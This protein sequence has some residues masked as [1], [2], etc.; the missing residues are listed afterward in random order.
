MFP[1]QPVARLSGAKMLACSDARAK[2]SPHA[3][4]GIV[5][6]L[7]SRNVA[8][9]CQDFE[10]VLYAQFAVHSF[11]DCLASHSA[12][13]RTCSPCRNPGVPGR[14]Q[15]QNCRVFLGHAMRPQKD[16]RG[17]SVLRKSPRRSV[18]GRLFVPD[19]PGRWHK[20]T[21]G[22]R[23]DGF[24]PGRAT[25]HARAPQRATTISCQGRCLC[26]EMT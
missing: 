12:C 5:Y 23:T 24:T 21:P 16:S 20:E 17:F 10:F 9:A 7:I 8:H 13:A 4:Y 25:R 22:A 14:L 1:F 2:R 18:A 26:H 15:P 3:P 19:R 11:Q 6:V